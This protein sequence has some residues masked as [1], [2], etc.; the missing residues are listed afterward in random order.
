MNN[1]QKLTGIVF[2]VVTMAV[3]FGLH[4]TF[5]VETAEATHALKSCAVKLHRVYGT[6][7]YNDYGIDGGYTDTEI[8]NCWSCAGLV[9]AKEHVRH[10]YFDREAIRKWYEHKH[11]VGLFWS[12]CHV[13]RDDSFRW[14]YVLE[15]CGTSA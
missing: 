8:T 12:D 7:I 10:W 14:Y 11:V 4:I 3:V 1:N 15:P 9:S 6:S 5:P 13:H 2:T